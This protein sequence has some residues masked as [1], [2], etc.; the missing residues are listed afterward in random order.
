MDIPGPVGRS[1]TIRSII[2][3]PG[4][5]LSAGQTADYAN[6]LYCPIA[7]F[8]TT[9]APAWR[10]TSSS[11]HAAMMGSAFCHLGECPHF[12]GDSSAFSDYRR[13]HFGIS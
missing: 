2:Q 3:G 8:Y 9:G 12:N 11:S 6:A 10:G 13:I 7:Y 4:E 1:E 5:K